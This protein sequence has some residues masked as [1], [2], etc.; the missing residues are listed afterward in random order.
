AVASDTYLA[1]TPLEIDRLRA[2]ASCE[3]LPCS[4]SRN[5]SLIMRMSI[6][7]GG[8][9]SPG[10]SQEPTSPRLSHAQ[11][12]K[13][14]R[15][16]SVTIPDRS[17]TFPESAVT[18]PDQPVTIGRNTHLVPHATLYLYRVAPQVVSWLYCSAASPRLR[19]DS[20]CA[21][22]ACGLVP[23]KV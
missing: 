15:T 11:P 14:Y 5:T 4:L 6:V 22:E 13:P 23:K 3:S 7:G 10:K 21:G 12:F 17:V 8:I 20:I 18:L 9:G 19:L 1:T 16:P 2:I